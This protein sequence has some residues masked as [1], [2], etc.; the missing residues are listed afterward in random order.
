MNA[1]VEELNKAVDDLRARIRAAADDLESG[2]A[3]EELQDALSLAMEEIAEL[4]DSLERTV[5][6]NPLLVL[7]GALA[8]GYLVGS[9]SSR[10]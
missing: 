4:Q 9:L 2:A 3:G 6:K 5:R 7:G 1:R 8:V 10:R